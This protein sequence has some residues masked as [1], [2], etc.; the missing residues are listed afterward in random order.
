MI[1]YDENIKKLH[2]SILTLEKFEKN[3][4]FPRFF[5]GQV[6]K[7]LHSFDSYAKRYINLKY[8]RLRD[9][10]T[11][12]FRQSECDKRSGS[13]MKITPRSSPHLDTGHCVTS[14]WQLR[15]TTR[16]SGGWKT[17]ENV[18]TYVFRMSRVDRRSD[19]AEKTAPRTVRMS[20]VRLG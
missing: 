12:F 13:A 5:L 6:G 15:D 4:N 14:V 2:Y 18:T 1:V 3:R 17:P 16:W 10:R 19:R 9:T 20:E 11:L 7:S 8:P